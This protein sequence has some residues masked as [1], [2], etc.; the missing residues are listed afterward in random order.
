M[1]K[2]IEHE[3]ETRVLEGV[4]EFCNVEKPKYFPRVW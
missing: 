4:Q 3:T 2:N 1:D